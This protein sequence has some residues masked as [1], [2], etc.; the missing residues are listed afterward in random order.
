MRC[1]DCG[2]L[3]YALTGMDKVRDKLLEGYI[4]INSGYIPPTRNITKISITFSRFSF[5]CERSC[6]LSIM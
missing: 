1:E 5:D 3:M 4:D 6:L 2:D